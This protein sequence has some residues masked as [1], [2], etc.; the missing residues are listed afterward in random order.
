MD[1]T[2]A[3]VTVNTDA[4]LGGELAAH[5]SYVERPYH[6]EIFGAFHDHRYVSVTFKLFS[7]LT[8]AQRQQ[9]VDSVL[10]SFAW[11]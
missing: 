3:D 9:T 7:T 2:A 10:A 1:A 4:T 8:P 11:K 6:V 5:A